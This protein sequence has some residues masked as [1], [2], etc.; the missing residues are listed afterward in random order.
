MTIL[1]GSPSAPAISRAK[2]RD[3]LH[4]VIEHALELLDAVDGDP[5]LEDACEDEGGQCDDEG[6]RDAY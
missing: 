1:N 3:C 5:D 4:L 6:H 2:M